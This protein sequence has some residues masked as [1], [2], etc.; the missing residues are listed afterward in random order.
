MA[1]HHIVHPNPICEVRTRARLAGLL[2]AI[3]VDRLARHLDVPGDLRATLESAARHIAS[4]QTRGAPLSLSMPLVERYRHPVA[5]DWLVALLRVAETFAIGSME[6]NCEAREALE[7]MRA[8]PDFYPLTILAALACEV[9]VPVQETCE[10]LRACAIA[11]GFGFIIAAAD[12]EERE[13]IEEAE[14]QARAKAARARR[15]HV[16]ALFA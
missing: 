14:A 4:R 11:E 10:E 16:K 8:H 1:T 6:P 13:E 5:G 12:R 15:R 2:A 3:W 9:G 7:M